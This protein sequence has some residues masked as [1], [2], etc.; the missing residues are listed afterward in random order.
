[1]D[2]KINFI[3]PTIVIAIY[4]GLL[5]NAAFGQTSPGDSAKFSE[6]LINIEQQLMNDI[7]AGNALNWDK[8]LDKNFFI[9]TEDGSMLEKN[10]FL[11]TLGALPKGY[12][13]YIKVI[14]P[15]IVF[16]QNTAVI[17][18]VSDEYETVFEN[19]IHTQYSS[20]NTYIK[21]DTSWMMISSQVFEIPLLPPAINLPE[22]VLKQYTGLY[23][24]AD[25]ILCIVS[26]ENDTLYC[27]KKGRD[28]TA[29]LPETPNTFFRLSDAR[30]RK[31]FTTDDN[32]IMLM[33]ERRNGQDVIWKRIKAS[34][35]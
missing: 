17:S 20:M 11:K 8:Y 1:M 3:K 29:L 25:N 35:Q 7:P 19:K 33:R 26:L 9:I 13:G 15:K 28:K 27:Q 2:I 18:Y 21:T 14:K 24:L 4:F 22:N 23:K 12:S 6:H 34:Q 5:F 31:I 30:G 32:G 16:H 10:A